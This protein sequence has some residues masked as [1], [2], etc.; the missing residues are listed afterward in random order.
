MA[1]A[2]ELR[3]LH[4]GAP[5]W[6][7]A[8]LVLGVRLDEMMEMRATISGPADSEALH[9]LRISAKR[10]RYSLEMFMVCFPDQL[11]QERADGVRAM[12]DVLGRIHDLDVLHG[13]LQEQ[14]AQIDA[15][16]REDALRIA[17][18]PADGTHRDDDLLDHS[19]TDGISNG[20]LGLYKVIAA[21][22][23]ERRDLY[24]RF[25]DLWSEWEDAGFLVAI[26]AS[27]TS[28]LHP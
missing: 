1:P 7:T 18:S 26:R 22:A 4:G 8:R 2:N 12:Q 15:E 17:L 9:A 10:L 28:E 6:E 14:V 16:A 11:A 21:K 5:L 3:N 19:R 23:D 24:D 20:R 13:L 27:L 25:V